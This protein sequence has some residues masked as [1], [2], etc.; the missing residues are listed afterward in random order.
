MAARRIGIG[1]L[2]KLQRHRFPIAAAA[3]VDR[4]V[5]LPAQDRRAEVFDRLGNLAKNRQSLCYHYST[6]ARIDD[7]DSFHPAFEDDASGGGSAVTPD[8]ERPNA[9]L[10]FSRMSSGELLKT[11]LNLQVMA[12]GPLVDVGIKVLKSPVA[13]HRFLKKPIEWCVKRTI[14]SHFCAGENAAEAS[15]TLQKLWELRLRGV[16]DSGLEDA[17]DNAS[18]DEN[19]QQLLATIRETI[20]LPHGSVSYACVKITAIAPLSLL[21]KLSLLLRWQHR[22]PEVELPWKQQDGL[23]L[24]APESPTYHAQTEPEPLTREEESDLVLA[25]ERLSKLCEC[26]ELQGLPLLVD[27]EYTSVQPAIDYITYTAAVKFNRGSQPLVHGTIQAYLKDS[28]SRLEMVVHETTKRGIPF[29]VKLVRGAYLSRET[30]L[31]K[32]LGVPS[33]IH[34]SIQDTHRCYDRCAAF[35]LEQASRGHGSIVLATH[36]FESGKAAAH[37]SEEL[38]MRRGDLRVHFAQLKGMADGLSLSLV[39]AGFQV[40]KYL[41]FGP[42][43]RVIQ[44]LIRRAEENRGLLGNSRDDR[45]WISKELAARWF[46]L[47]RN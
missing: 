19:L 23:P 30:A 47:P 26:C 20:A 14:Y 44:Y 36:N 21:E 42:V 3:V 22:N 16:L 38:G 11:L 5:L 6:S 13:N 34:A 35:M 25:L 28:L 9:E 4:A 17:A 15:K 1:S 27:A 43:P 12:C 8:L 18:C 46:G 33:P 37:K 10:L 31:A 41:P 40:S 29:G 2:R 24:F 7:A 45:R 32:V 39:Q